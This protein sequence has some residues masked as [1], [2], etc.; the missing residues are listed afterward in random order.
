MGVIKGG[1]GKRSNILTTNENNSG[2]LKTKPEGKQKGR[3][4]LGT[5]RGMGWCIKTKEKTQPEGEKGEI[6]GGG[7]PKEGSPWCGK[8]GKSW[9]RTT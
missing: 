2:P 3:E 6:Q 1:A 9:Q 5:T 4:F 7:E 8:G